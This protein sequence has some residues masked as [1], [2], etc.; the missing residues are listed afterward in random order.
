[1]ENHESMLGA[2]AP[3]RLQTTRYDMTRILVAALLAITLTAPAV[4]KPDAPAKV[5]VGAIPAYPVSGQV[6]ALSG[7]PAAAVRRAAASRQPHQA[8]EARKATPEPSYGQI[9]FIAHPTGC[10]RRNFCACGASVRVFGHSIRA[11]WPVRAWRQ[12]ARDVAAPGNVAIERGRSHLFVLESHVSGDYWMVSDY[13]SGGHLSRRH[14]R[15]VAGLP[16][17]NPHSRAFAA[18][19][20]SKTKRKNQ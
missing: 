20:K 2:L 13:N 9:S 6:K 3:P 8:E 4:A 19:E 7:R 16:I 5:D 15:S 10:P 12:F 18:V 1:M 14:V 17:V 11:L